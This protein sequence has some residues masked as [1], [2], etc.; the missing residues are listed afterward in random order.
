MIAAPFIHESKIIIYIT[1]GLI[2][3][4]PAER[5]RIT[6]H[7]VVIAHPVYQHPKKMEFRS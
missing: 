6:A 7:V 5:S 3:D 2:S 1:N 4:M